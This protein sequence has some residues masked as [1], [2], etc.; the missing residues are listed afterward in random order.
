MGLLSNADFIRV[1]ATWSIP[2]VL[3]FHKSTIFFFLP[4]L[5]LYSKVLVG[6]G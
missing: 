6:R 1:K 4:L 3:L 2:V 5:E